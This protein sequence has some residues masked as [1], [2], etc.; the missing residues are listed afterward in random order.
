MY[1][2]FAASYD[3]ICVTV[4][5]AV[6]YVFGRFDIYRLAKVGGYC[7]IIYRSLYQLTVRIMFRLLLVVLKAQMIA[8]MGICICRHAPLPWKSTLGSDES[9]GMGRK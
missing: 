9:V 8:H 1:C 3:I 2:S 4:L 6:K 7:I 5:I